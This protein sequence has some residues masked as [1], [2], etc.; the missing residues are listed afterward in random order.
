ML[1]WVLKYVKGFV[2]VG[3]W[4]ESSTQDLDKKLFPSIEQMLESRRVVKNGKNYNLTYILPGKES[5]QVVKAW[6]VQH[7]VKGG[8]FIKQELAWRW[9][10]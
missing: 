6:E 7:E 9:V 4:N 5:S 1:I 3:I 2:K 10:A 8:D